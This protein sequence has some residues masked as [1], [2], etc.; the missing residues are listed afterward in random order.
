MELSKFFKLLS[1][2]TRLRI[3]VLLTNGSLCVGMI[4]EALEL[5]QPNVSKHLGKLRDCGLLK[6]ERQEQFIFYSLNRDNLMLDSILNRINEQMESYEIFKNDRNRLLSREGND[7]Y[8]IGEE[9]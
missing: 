6:D 4:C 8:C 2:D 9:Q 3:I 5:S 1:D 7:E